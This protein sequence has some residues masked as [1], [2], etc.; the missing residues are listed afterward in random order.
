MGTLTG[1]IPA[2]VLERHRDPAADDAGFAPEGWPRWAA[3]YS[4]T[5]RDEGEGAWA[6]TG[7]TVIARLL[8]PWPS[9]PEQS[10]A[11]ASSAILLDNTGEAS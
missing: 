9:L 4:H 3:D 2:V 8:S 5:P 11:H 1:S 10:R 6:Q 7:P